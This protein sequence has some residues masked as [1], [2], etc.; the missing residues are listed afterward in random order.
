[1]DQRGS[2]TLGL[3]TFLKG[4][5]VVGRTAA[6]LAHLPILAGPGFTSRNAGSEA[7]K[8]KYKK[9]EEIAV[10]LE[11]CNRPFFVYI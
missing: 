5:P 9:A 10:T 4:V 3:K 6:K 1:M 8:V 7:V 2:S 11:S